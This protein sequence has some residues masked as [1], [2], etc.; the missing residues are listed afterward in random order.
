MNF[1]AHLHLASLAKS[2]LTGNLL[3]DFLRGHDETKLPNLIRSGIQLHRWVDVYIDNLP[4]VNKAKSL[5]RP[6]TRRVAPIALDIFWDHFLSLHWSD[7]SPHQSLDE[8]CHSAEQKI[9]PWLTTMP[10]AF[11]VLNNKMW[12]ERWLQQ[13]ASTA[14][15]ENVLTQMARRRPKLSSLA[16]CHID[17][18][19][20]YAQL[21]QYFRDFYPIM[22]QCVQQK[23]SA[24]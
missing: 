16:A 2:S 13:Y 20:Q 23:A 8:F 1:L 3:A 15:I 7:Y 19:Q 17:F 24:I 10:D 22:M 9:I 6:E 11:R 21:E 14:T 12:T 4:Q 5:F 18:L